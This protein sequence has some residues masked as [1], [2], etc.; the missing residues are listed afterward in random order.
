MKRVGKVAYRLKLL[1]HFKVH[2][3]FH[4][5]FLKPFH[6][7]GLNGQTQARRAPPTVRKQFDKEIK[8]ILDHRVLGASKKNKRA[9]Y[10][11]QWKGSSEVDVIWEKVTDLWPFKDKINSYLDAL[12][13]TR[14][15]NSSGG[16]LLAP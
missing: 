6:E 2:P 1:D 4:F 7:D 14:T 12:P 15:S 11:V 8:K 13:S 9:K 3:T 5:S 10:L 16:G